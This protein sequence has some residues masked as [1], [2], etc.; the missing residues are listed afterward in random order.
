MHHAPRGSGSDA[1]ESEIRSGIR[2]NEIHGSEIRADD[3]LRVL[4]VCPAV[5]EEEWAG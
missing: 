2:E 1:R 3:F 5:E 4:V